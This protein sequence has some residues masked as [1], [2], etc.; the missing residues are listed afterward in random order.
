MKIVAIGDIHGKTIWKDIV[1]KEK[2]ADK[3]VFVGDF[4][5]TFEN[6]SRD[7]QV[8]NLKEVLEY[9]REN[10]E[11]IVI[12][13]GN[14]DYHYLPEVSRLG[15]YYSGFQGSILHMV[16]H[17]FSD[18]ILNKEIVGCYLYDNVL[19]THAGVTKTWCENYYVNY[20]NL[21]ESINNL[22]I[23]NISSFGFQYSDKRFSVNP[24]GDDIFQS[25]TWVRP[26]SLI[27][28][29]LDD[30]IQVVGHTRMNSI[31]LTDSVY[32]IDC[33]DSAGEYLVY[34]D[35]KFKYESV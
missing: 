23:N 3:I 29:K 28:D 25:P 26:E 9:K 12:L 30:Y 21:E 6:I 35:G 11:Q 4:L 2:D 33:L 7:A 19:F 27:I 1:E 16:T 22:L 15:I 31:T 8:R 34:E 32:F 5:D 14:H 10:P 20:D 13:V 18:S 24:Y 17:L